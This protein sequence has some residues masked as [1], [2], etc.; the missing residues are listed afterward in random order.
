[1]G[2]STHLLF[3]LKWIFIK[4]DKNCWQLTWFV[5]RLKVTNQKIVFHCFLYS[6][7]KQKLL[8][9]VF[10]SYKWTTYCINALKGNNCF[11]DVTRHVFLVKRIAFTV[12]FSQNW[13]NVKFLL[14]TLKSSP[15]QSRPPAEADVFIPSAQPPSCFGFNYKLKKVHKL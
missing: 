3:L 10:Y 7:K 14:R 1:M 12:S 11:C 15:T 9:C 6:L 4:V 5:I 8:I 2:C 13:N